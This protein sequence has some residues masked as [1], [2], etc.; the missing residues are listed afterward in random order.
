MF[1]AR[2]DTKILVEAA[3]RLSAE[4]M[5]VQMPDR[6]ARIRAA[7]RH[8]A[9]ALGK[10]ELL[11]QLRDYGKDM[12]DQRGIVLAELRRRGDMRLRHH[13]KMLRCKRLN[14][15]EGEA[16]LILIELFSTGSLPQ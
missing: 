2:P 9:E 15:V 12:P 5:E 4:H 11:R 10:A 6:L 3:Q 7:I 13:Q 1:H 8:Y 16:Q 14:V